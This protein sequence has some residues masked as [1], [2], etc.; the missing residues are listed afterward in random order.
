MKTSTVLLVGGGV[1]ATGIGFLWYQRSKAQ[2]AA[3][4]AQQQRPAPS[5]IQAVLNGIVGAAS[6]LGTTATGAGVVVA[7]VEGIV[8]SLKSIFG[9]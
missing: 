4:A 6:N 5:G 1:V 3:I 7:G 2:Q 8:G 9:R